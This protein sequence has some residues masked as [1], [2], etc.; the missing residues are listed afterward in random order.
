MRRTTNLRRRQT[1][2]KKAGSLRARSHRSLKF[3]TP[4]L[5][6]AWGVRFLAVESSTFSAMEVTPEPGPVVSRITEVQTRIP[7][8]SVA[9]VV[10]WTTIVVRP[11]IGRPGADVLLPGVSIG[12]LISSVIGWTNRLEGKLALLRRDT[13]RLFEPKSQHGLRRDH[14]WFSARAHYA[15]NSSRG[16]DDCPDRGAFSAFS[17]GTNYSANACSRPDGRRVSP[18]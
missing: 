12:I 10:P 4:H 1:A 18:R 16:P 14:R 17:S 8:V 5:Q 2:N 9:V 11:W 15:D 6:P 7:R 3:R 13:Q